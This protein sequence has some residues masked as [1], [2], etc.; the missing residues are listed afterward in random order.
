MVSGVLF[1]YSRLPILAVLLPRFFRVTIHGM[2][3]IQL[4]GEKL[5]P[6]CC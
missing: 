6:G 4:N 5:M 1:D 3:L 2:L